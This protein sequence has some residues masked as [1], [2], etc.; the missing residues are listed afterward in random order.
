MP[1]MPRPG[2]IR[3]QAVGTS[4]RFV[5]PKGLMP[6]ALKCFG[7]TAVSG[8]A[9]CAA[10]HPSVAG[11]YW[12]GTAGGGLWKTTDFGETWTPI[13]DKWLSMTVSAIAIHPADPNIMIVG[14]GQWFAWQS[15]PS[16]LMRTT[17]GGTTWEDI[18]PA[19]LAT[20]GC[21]IRT[22]G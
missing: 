7:P 20:S 1:T 6:T 3:A 13:G 19:R 9:L 16:G 11:T 12:V 8:N 5:G 18:S 21:A 2:G 15:H 22:G 14:M 10:Y 4:W 17:D